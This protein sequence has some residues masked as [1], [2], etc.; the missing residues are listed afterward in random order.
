MNLLSETDGETAVSAAVSF[1][2][3]AVTG[4]RAQ[5]A[6]GSPVVFPEIFSEPRGVFVTLT[7]NGDLRG[8]IGYPYPVLP[9]KAALKDAAY[10]AALSDPRFYPVR[11][12]EL[13]FL[14]VEVTI[15]SLPEKLTVP[16]DLSPSVIEVGK[17]GLIAESHGMR[18]LLLPQVATEWGWDAAEFLD[19]TC[20][21]AGLPADEWQKESCT[22]SVFEG[23]IF[24]GVHPWQ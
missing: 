7:E 24:R 8:C 5:T 13:P 6:A 2:T 12:E 15:L 22:I 17:H 3:D 4:G 23:Q 11:A 9:L 19:Q 21:K 10:Q 18:G 16:A 20:I 14:D 1:I